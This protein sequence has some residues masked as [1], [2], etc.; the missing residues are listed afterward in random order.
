MSPADDQPTRPVPPARP[1]QPAVGGT[2][3]PPPARTWE[4]ELA[5]RI[6]TLR[7]WLVL[8][9][10]VTVVATGI[11]I[12]ALVQANDDQ[13]QAGSGATSA[14]L[15]ELEDRVTE[16]EN[17]G[18]SDAAVAQLKSDVSDLDARVQ[19]LESGDQAGVTPEQLDTLQ[20]RVADLAQQI[21]D[22]LSQQTP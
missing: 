13:P 17:S 21:E 5:E 19:K 16:L 18:A 10:I 9:G 6:S 12:Y 4:E 2:P 3:A 22:L 8:L 1:R 14:Q 11:A 7:N 20:E 15:N